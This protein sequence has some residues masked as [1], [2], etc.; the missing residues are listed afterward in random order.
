MFA[1]AR[2]CLLA[3]ALAYGTAASADIRSE[4]KAVFEQDVAQVDLAR[5]KLELDRMVAPSV[6]VEAELAQI[7][8][9]AT[10]LGNPSIPDVASPL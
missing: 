3:L 2:L 10:E 7:A 6:D 5:A 9:M 4:V 8:A 1:P